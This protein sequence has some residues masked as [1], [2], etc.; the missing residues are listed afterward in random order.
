M[1]AAGNSAS[2]TTTTSKS[3]RKQQK[4]RINDAGNK[5]DTW[6]LTST[7]TDRAEFSSNEDLA[8]CKKGTHWTELFLLL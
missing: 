2:T 4:Q 3:P 7:A 5:R 1:N 8:T 6:I